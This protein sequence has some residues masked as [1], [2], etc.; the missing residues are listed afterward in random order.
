[1]YVKYIYISH[2]VD[3]ARPDRMQDKHSYTEA[4]GGVSVSIY[5]SHCSSRSHNWLQHRGVPRLRLGAKCEGL[6][7]A[8]TGLCRKPNGDHPKWLSHRV[9]KSAP[10]ASTY[11]ANARH[12][13]A[14]FELP[15]KAWMALS[16]NHTIKSLPA[17]RTRIFRAALVQQESR[18]VRRKRTVRTATKP[19]LP[20]P[21][22]VTV[23]YQS[24]HHA[25]ISPQ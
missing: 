12:D 20:R 18:C 25:C 24:V 19:T 1:M 14:A 3:C 5:A 7:T 9:S 16:T 13:N 23:Q 15:N 11:S 2:G 10:G 4:V 17:R 8:D 6:P 21:L 22:Y